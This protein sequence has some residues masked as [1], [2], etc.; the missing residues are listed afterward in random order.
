M[1]IGG[2]ASLAVS[3]P[4][5]TYMYVSCSWDDGIDDELVID[6][7]QTAGIKK[8]T[9]FPC[10]WGDLSRRDADR[11]YD[12][13]EVGNHTFRHHKA[14]ELSPDELEADIR[15]ME[16]VL[17]AKLGITPKGF[18]FPFGDL[19]EILHEQVISL[20]YQYTRGVRKQLEHPN[21]IGPNAEFGRPG[22][23]EA[24]KT[25]GKIFVFYGH[26]GLTTEKE[27]KEAFLRMLGDGC[28]FVTHAELT[29]KIYVPLV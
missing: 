6:A 1:T 27:L 8:V 3:H 14:S 17:R 25:A 5:H 24:Y 15:K 7:L 4:L 13:Y 28:V 2:L 22:F 26:A 29:R 20:G 12:G 21:F 16:E 19:N 9:F 23:W 18:A 10:V 11:L